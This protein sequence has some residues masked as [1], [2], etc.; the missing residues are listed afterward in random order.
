[1]CHRTLYYET[2]SLEVR[3]YISFSTMEKGNSR[4]APSA[5]IIVI[6]N[7]ILKGR[8]QDTNSRFIAQKLNKLGV[9]VKKIS[10]IGD[11]LAAIS[12]EVRQFSEM[13]THV[14]TSG[15]IGPTHDDVTFEGVADAFNDRLAPH[16]ELV[17]FIGAYFKTED[18]ASPPMKM[19]HVVPF[20]TLVL[21]IPASAHLV[22]AED[23][24]SGYKS[25]FP[26]VCVNNVTVLPGVPDLL[27][28]SFGR[29]AKQLFGD[30]GNEAYEDVYLSVDEVTVAAALNNTAS[31]FPSVVIGSY[32]QLMHSY[33]KTHLT[34]ESADPAA[35]QAARKHFMDQID[36]GF[37]VRSFVTDSVQESWPRIQRLLH[38]RPTLQA[39]VSQS[40]QVL[41]ECLQQ[42][43]LEEICI[44]FNGGKDCL[45]A[46]HLF[47]AILHGG[48]LEGTDAES[49]PNKL[50]AVYIREENAFP[51]INKFVH[52]TI[53]RYNLDCIIL[54]GP[55][56][57]ALHEL[58]SRRPGIKA[59]IMGTRDSDPYSQSLS[60]FQ[61]T[62]KDWP[63][64][65]R[66]HPILHWDYR[67]VWDF[68]RG[69]YL[70][71]C[72]LYDRGYSSL[73]NASNTVQN[74]LLLTKDRLGA[75]TYK[76]AYLLD[77]S[78]QERNGRT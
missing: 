52:E 62:D 29:L 46:L 74:P 53:N 14:I 51:Q 71:Y 16:P 78:N 65:M 72:S 30:H 60:S 54:D 67:T 49:F 59:V 76:P 5:G 26:V 70:P 27:E 44:C 21:Q 61:R 55:M 45:V 69:L 18:L 2:E 3:A 66:V 10:V 43:K 68:I 33:Y 35:V 17:S 36:P 23:R 75:P 57:D 48:Q 20:L 28:K 58:L 7:E 24:A 11:E 34:F 31:A 47:Y 37:E 25:K 38:E 77:D 73:G 12:K 50:Q 40:L 13:Y 39:N 56:K 6:G 15:G 1:M 64:F 63:V 19:A 4:A 32:P 41:R 8:T 42:Y 22:Y 9:Q